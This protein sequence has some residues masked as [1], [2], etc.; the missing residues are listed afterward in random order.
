MIDWL[1][2][3]L[4]GSLLSP[5]VRAKFV[6]RQDKIVKLSPDGEVLWETPAR[7]SIRSDTHQITVRLA[8]DLVIFGSPAR[9]MHSNNVF[10]STDMI[11]CFHAMREYVASQLE[12]ILPTSPKIWKCTMIDITE[13]YML[14]SL[15]EVKQALNYLRHSEGGRYQVRT[16]AETI[17]WSK[18]SRLRAGKAYAK[19]PHLEYQKKKGQIKITD[20]RL[21]AAQ[22]LLRL[23]LRLGSQF[24]RERSEKSWY[25]YTSNDLCRIHN[26]YFSQ[27]IGDIELTENDDVLEKL[28]SITTDGQAFAAYRTWK[29]IRTDGMETTRSLMPKSTWYRHKKLLNKVGISWADFKN[30][31][32]VPFRKKTIML[33]EPIKSWGEISNRT[34]NRK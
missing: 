19:G 21:Q 12:I 6:Q 1:T 7:T 28:N 14:D 32:I 31:N 4:D 16:S 20:D 10:G 26:D 30:G 8:S 11:E 18:T 17:Y 24:W 25:E 34:S 23:E 9:V 3:K 15:S 33:S 29:L 2:L 22:K 5:D 13:N 27:F